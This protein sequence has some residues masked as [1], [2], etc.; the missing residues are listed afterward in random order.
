MHSRGARCFGRP[1]SRNTRLN[2]AASRRPPPNRPSLPSRFDTFFCAGC[3]LFVIGYFASLVQ[4]QYAAPLVGDDALTYHLPVAGHWLQTGYLSLYNTWFFNPANTYSP[5]AGSVFF[6]WLIAPIRAD[7]LAQ[8]GQ[9]PAL[10]LTFFAF[11]Q[12]TRS[13][14]VRLSIASLI[15]VAALL[16]RPFIAEAILVKDDHGFLAA[17]FLVAI[18]GCAPERLR[19]R[20]GPWRIGIAIG[21]F[22]ATKY[23]AFLTAPL[24]LLVIDAPFRARWSFRQYLLSAACGLAVAA[25]WYLRNLILT[26]NPLYPATLSLAG[27]PI[28]H[29]LFIF[30]RSTEMRTLTGAWSAFTAGYTALAP[31]FVVLLILTWLGARFFSPSAPPAAILSLVSVSSAPRS[32]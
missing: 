13:L 18:A 14:G 25:P 2:A 32:D 24:F 8:F 31:T 17:F 20:L 5:L 19:D 26:A 22:F 23:T 4:L 12:L 11:L 1:Q 21:L 10:I 27:H 6:T 7:I 15:A 30:D 28:L 9:M 29:G 3:L 16:S